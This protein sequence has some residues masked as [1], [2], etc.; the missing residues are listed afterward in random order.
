MIHKPQFEKQGLRWSPNS[1]SELKFR[2]LPQTL[3]FLRFCFCPPPLP[4]APGIGWSLSSEIQSTFLHNLTLPQFPQP[5]QI[6]LLNQMKKN[7]QKASSPFPSS[8]FRGKHIGPFCLK[9]FYCSSFRNQVRGNSRHFL[10]VLSKWEL[11]W[12]Y[13]LYS[14]QNYI[15]SLHA[16]FFEIVILMTL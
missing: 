5:P 9:K 13:R 11:W 16:K 12:I 15:F 4:Q 8:K 3:H 2:F 7:G 6:L 10:P 1:L 14:L